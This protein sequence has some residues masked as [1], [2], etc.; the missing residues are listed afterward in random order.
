[1]M[2]R[3]MLILLMSV[4]IWGSAFPQ[5]LS[6]D[7]DDNFRQQANSI[8]SEGNRYY[9]RS[10][11]RGIALMAD[12]LESLLM[13]RSNAGKLNHID[14]LE[15]TA[16]L[17]KL[18]AD[19]HYENGNYDSQSY[20]IA[21][22]LFHNALHI[23][24]TNSFFYRH[25][26]KASLIHRE[27]AQLYYKIGEYDNALSYT[28][29]AL[30]AYRDAW[31]RGEI[32]DKDATYL[33]LQSQMAMCL[34]RVGDTNAALDLI[35][36]L[37]KEYPRSSE[38]YYELLRK[39]GKIMILSDRPDIDSK[40]LKCY[41]QYF[42]WCKTDALCSLSTMTAAERQDYWMRMR[43]FVADCYQLEQLAPDFLYDVTLFNKGLLLQINRM[44]GYGKTSDIAL[45]SLGYTWKNIQSRL[46]V[47]CAAIEFVQYEKGGKARMGALVLRK[48]GTP[49]WVTMPSPDD[50]MDYEIEGWTNRDRIYTASGY[51]K[52]DIYN[53]STL[54][55]LI[56]KKELCAAIGHPD[57]VYFAP[58]GYLH[59]LAIEYMLPDNLKNV[60]VFRLTSTRRLMDVT[61][62]HT[63]SALIVGGIQYDARNTITED[64]NDSDAY[65]Y[66]QNM[67]VSF[68][69]LPGTMQEADSI[70][71]VRY[72]S[73]DTLLTGNTAT[74]YAFR[75]L[76][77]KY[78][79]INIST[80]GYFGASEIPQS[81]DIKTSMSDESLSQCGIA[82]AGAN[83]NIMSDVFDSNK[84]D[85]ILSAKEIAESD[86]SNV[87]M[88]IIS[89]CQTGLGYVTA[90]GVFGI[91]RGLKNA[92]VESMLVSLWNV[93]DR[94]TSLLISQFH[95]NLQTGM[96]PHRAFMQAR[97]TFGETQPED[98]RLKRKFNANTMTEFVIVDNDYY[99]EPQ[100]RNAFI[101]IDAI[102]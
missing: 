45:K 48:T 101:M 93:D 98:D 42:A 92:G 74:E 80:H 83:T 50:F 76:C 55:A 2:K 77:S 89:A 86:L 32:D 23:Y 78:P 56:W 46:P 54:C 8:V 59:Q 47:G 49:R 99:D 36:K 69:Y 87:S 75:K 60:E 39:R 70:H 27:L 102:K 79:I 44:S 82:L 16:D 25:L 41:K 22:M 38:G 72:C 95:K 4:C 37:V 90:D 66:L 43:P 7:D 61:E 6:M 51:W 88:A 34:A 14:S 5:N 57:K 31:E 91:Q 1:M 10:Y 97:D 64:G 11:R 35:D 17:F 28:E 85:G 62:V 96:P 20:R 19:W 52:N 33:Q 94:A 53:D 12:S 18:Y 24:N 65:S 30:Y 15:F 81:T 58:D 13:Q 71:S 26:D 29:M 21:E 3:L 63:D 100:Y 9:D 67:Q 73:R 84:M 68:G 40:A